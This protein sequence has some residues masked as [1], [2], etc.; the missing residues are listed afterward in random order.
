MKKTSVLILYSLPSPRLP[1]GTPDI[2]GA[3]SVLSRLGYV[4]KALQ[5]LGYLVQ[6]L[7][8]KGD[9]LPVLEKIRNARV[10]II[11]N[12]CEEFNGQT[13]MEMNIAAALEIQEIPFTGSSALNPSSSGLGPRPGGVFFFVTISPHRQAPPG[14]CQPGHRSGFLY[15]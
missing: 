2:I 14:R 10:D 11:F 5:Q 4:E 9:L 15:P 1:N 6:T 8:A 7:E 3:K 12:L 13:G